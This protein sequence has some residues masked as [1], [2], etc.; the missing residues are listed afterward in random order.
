[1]TKTQVRWIVGAVLAVVLAVVILYVLNMPAGSE[2][3]T[4][5]P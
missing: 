2:V 4:T 5:G 1:M 3:V